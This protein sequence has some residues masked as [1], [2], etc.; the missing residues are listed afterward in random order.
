MVLDVVT[1]LIR[2]PKTLDQ[3]V[4][5]M[6]PD[7]VCGRPLEWVVSDWDFNWVPTTKL[8]GYLLG[9]YLSKAAMLASATRVGDHS[10]VEMCYG[11][12]IN[13]AGK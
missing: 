13:T 6:G 12:G 5:W 1:V 4:R 9:G 3:A 8:G 2:H 11:P 10:R 7:K